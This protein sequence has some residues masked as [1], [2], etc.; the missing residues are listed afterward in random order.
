MII[1]V[2][3]IYPVVPSW[4]SSQY[5]GFEFAKERNYKQFIKILFSNAGLVSDR[6]VRITVCP[7]KR[8]LLDNWP[9]FLSFSTTIENWCKR[10]WPKM[11]F[12]RWEGTTFVVKL[13]PHCPLGIT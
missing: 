11:F 5:S 8:A 2:L 6:R 12:K 3:N 1:N 9:N 13:V 7:L 4:P 10:N